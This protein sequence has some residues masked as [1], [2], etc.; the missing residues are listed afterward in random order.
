MCDKAMRNDAFSLVCVPN[1]F[2]T[3][4]QLKL[5]QDSYDWHNDDEVIGW[6]EDYKKRKAQKA[7]IK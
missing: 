4:E 5:W 1:W 3:E 2:V 7:K 6:Y